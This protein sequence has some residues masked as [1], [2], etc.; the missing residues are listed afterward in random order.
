MPSP[1]RMV[2]TIG[3]AASPSRPTRTWAPKNAVIPPGTAM[4][5]TTRQST[6]PNFQCA[7]PEARVVPTSDRCTM[8]EAE[9]GAIPASSSREVEVTP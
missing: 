6:L 9:A 5:P 4:I 7:A 3:L 1:S 2:E 8:A